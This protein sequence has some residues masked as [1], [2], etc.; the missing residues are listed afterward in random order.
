M[1][2]SKASTTGPAPQTQTRPAP[3]QSGLRVSQGRVLRSEWTKF[4]SLR[5]TVIT[6]GVT[7]V[8]M[9]AIS[10]LFAAVTA[11]QYHTFSGKDRLDFNPISTSLGGI[12]FAQLAI[13]VLGVLL[14]SGEYSTGMI[15]SS[16]T[17]VPRRL[18]VLWGKL[19]VFGGVAFV[20]TLIT[21]TVA[22]FAGQSLLAGKGLDVSITSPGAVR[23]VFGAALYLT[24]AGMFGIALG[25]LLRNTAGGITTFVGVFFVVPPLMGLLPSSISD[26]VTQYLPSN[27]GAVVYDG[28]RDLHG[29][30]SPWVGLAVMCAYLVALLGAAAW[31]LS[32]TDA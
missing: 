21:A 20:V 17:A 26:H 19:G 7:V 12:S 14:M 18:P 13:G 11:N 27:A 2:A 30:L 31:R 25:A 23:S 9:I 10:A 24:V 4:R 1:T 8:L 15:R 29:A 3:G 16:L 32:R 5:S 22:F 6:L 28:T